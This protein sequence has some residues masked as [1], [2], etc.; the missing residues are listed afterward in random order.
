MLSLGE[1]N[2][3]QGSGKSTVI[4]ESI[5]ILENLIPIT[6]FIAQ[7]WDLLYRLWNR[8][9]FIPPDTWCHWSPAALR[10]SARVN[11]LFHFYPLVLSLHFHKCRMYGYILLEK[12]GF[13]LIENLVFLILFLLSSLQHVKNVVPT[14]FILSRCILRIYV[15]MNW[16]DP[17]IV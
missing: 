1:L 9:F 4:W 3:S 2:D 14:N 15:F 17:W 7:L 16:N 6:P 10:P 8:D 12:L 5:G 11:L 13:I